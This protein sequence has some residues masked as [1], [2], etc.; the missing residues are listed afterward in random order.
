MI[1]DKVKLLVEVEYSHGETLDSAEVAGLV[2]EAVRAIV[3]DGTFLKIPS[4]RSTPD[5]RAIRLGHFSF[6]D[7]D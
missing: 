1:K 6:W 3:M 7:K 5:E 2:R 4:T